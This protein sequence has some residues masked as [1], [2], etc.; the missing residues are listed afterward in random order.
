MARQTVFT[1]STAN[2]G[3]GDSLRSGA[4]KIN[5]NFTELYDKF[6]KGGVVL[7]ELVDF[8]SASINFGDP[9][10]TYKTNLSAAGPTANRAAVL[11]D[12]SGNIVIDT[13]TQTLTNKNLD[14]CVSINPRIADTTQDHQYIITPAELTS[15]RIARL[16]LLTDSDSYVFAKTPQVITNKTLDSDALIN[17]R[18]ENYIRNY[19]GRPMLFLDNVIP[20]GAIAYNAL[21]VGNSATGNPVDLIP[22]GTDVNVDIRLR[23]KGNQGATLLSKRFAL[24]TSGAVTIGGGAFDS[25]QPLLIMDDTAPAGNIFKTLPNGSHVGEV[26]FIISRSAANVLRVTPD[27]FAQ[28]NYF[29]LASQEVAQLVWDGVS[30]FVINKSDV[31]IA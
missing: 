23:G 14:S 21:S 11:P 3:T 20:G 17:P 18:I 31:F 7:A 2:D 1:G 5:Q 26:R 16:P 15:N 28:G 24:D 29:E 10:A 27:S 19:D 30:W 6:G 12:H 4:V 25:D 8:D 13:A 9:T 22:V